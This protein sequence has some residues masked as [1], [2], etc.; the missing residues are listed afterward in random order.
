MVG[1]ALN[2]LLRAAGLR[3]ERFASGAAFL[4]WLQRETPDFVLLD[5]HIDVAPQSRGGAAPLNKS[6][7]ASAGFIGPKSNLSLQRQG[8]YSRPQSS[9]SARFGALLTAPRASDQETVR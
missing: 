1:K 5:L 4:D 9:E 3:A 7:P 8:A 2:R 6:S